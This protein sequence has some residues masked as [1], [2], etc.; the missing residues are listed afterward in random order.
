MKV[1]N[2]QASSNVLQISDRSVVSKDGFLKILAAQLQNQDPMN[3]GDNSEYIAQMAQFT[4][5]EQMQNLNS[6]MNNLLLSQK[7]NEGN[8]LIGKLVKV[9]TGEDT[10]I[11]GE[12]TG[13]KAETGIV[14]IVVNGNE[15]D[16]DNVVEVN[17]NDQDEE[18]EG[19]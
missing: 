16:V 19:I 13:T 7:V 6:S 5:L 14:K 18:V 4:A 12:V 11:T 1:Y 9:E 2:P 10:Y 8:M 17:K 3:A 15:Y